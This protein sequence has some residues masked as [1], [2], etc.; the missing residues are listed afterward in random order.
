MILALV[1]F[2]VVENYGG[3][4]YHRKKT[5]ASKII[6]SIVQLFLTHHHNTYFEDKDKDET[7]VV[8]ATKPMVEINS[9]T[10]YGKLV[11]SPQGTDVEQYLGIPFAKPPIGDLRFANPVPLSKFD[12]GNQRYFPCCFVKRFYIV[13]N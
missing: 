8:V 3:R 9:G 7:P 5:F 13:F 4:S 2:L 10:V 1:V 6:F 11:K 12:G